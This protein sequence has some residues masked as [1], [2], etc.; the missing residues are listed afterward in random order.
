MLIGCS[1]LWSN[2]AH[3]NISSTRKTPTAAKAPDLKHVRMLAFGAANAMG[4]KLLFFGP[5]ATSLTFSKLPHQSQLCA[6]KRESISFLN[7]KMYARV[8]ANCEVAFK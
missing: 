7:R 1:F 4:R 3:C 8:L 5:M 2:F 6:Q